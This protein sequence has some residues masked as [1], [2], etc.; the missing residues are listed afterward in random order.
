MPAKEQ[1]VMTELL[2]IV[3]RRFPGF[4]A[5]FA[6]ADSFSST[7]L[8]SLDFVDLIW[9]VETKYCIKLTDGDLMSI[10]TPKDLVEVVIAKQSSQL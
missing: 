2:E 3:G 5:A 6:D 4:A 8:D 1:N 7:G 10:K 9:E